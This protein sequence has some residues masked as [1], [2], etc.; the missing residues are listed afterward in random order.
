MILSHDGLVS[1]NP[2]GKA[3]S[4]PARPF[5]AGDSEDRSR[6]DS[7]NFR[8][9][10][11]YHIARSHATVSQSPVSGCCIG[12]GVICFLGGRIRGLKFAPDE[13]LRVAAAQFPAARFGFVLGAP[14]R[15]LATL[16]TRMLGLSHFVRHE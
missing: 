7:A 12:M 15:A 8:P 11:W 1:P 6:D 14:Q 3:G 9:K 16:G 5:A 4:A 10:E 2:I 13:G